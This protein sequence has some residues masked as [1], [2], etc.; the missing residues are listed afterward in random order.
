MASFKLMEMVRRNEGV[1]DQLYQDCL[2][3]WT[4]GVGH[5]VDVRKGGWCDDDT[6]AR[7]SENGFRLSPAVIDAYL[8]DD[9]VAAERDVETLMAASQETLNDARYAAL[10]SMAFNLGHHGFASFT[11]ARAAIRA[12]RWREAHDH[13]LDS[14][15][16]H[17]VP[18]R[19]KEIA[20]IIRHG[21]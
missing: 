12:G 5:L 17:Q 13:L 9:L 10:V 16:A 15:W 8:R 11:K 21:G 19:V 4:I 1:R 3:F 20:E 2:G 14:K 7:L 18:N 6:A